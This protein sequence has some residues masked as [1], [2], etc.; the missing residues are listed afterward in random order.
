MNEYGFH[1]IMFP[2]H[3]HQFYTLDNS[4]SVRNQLFP[5]KGYFLHLGGVWCTL[6]H[7]LQSGTT[8]AGIQ[9]EFQLNSNQYNQY[10]IIMY[11]HVYVKCKR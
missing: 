11:P 9:D 2:I 3:I 4:I 1:V 10:A 8:R 6:P 7:P 5:L